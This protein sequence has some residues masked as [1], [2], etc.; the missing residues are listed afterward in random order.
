[1]ESISTPHALEIVAKYV[2]GAL[3]TKD[4]FVLTSLQRTSTLVAGI[5][6][7]MDSPEHKA[8]SIPRSKTGAGGRSAIKIVS[9]STPQPFSTEMSV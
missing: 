1:M 7:V 8:V 2:P 4:G 6:K 3:M 9:W 5:D